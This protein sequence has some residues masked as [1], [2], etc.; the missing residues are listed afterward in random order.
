[1]T[2]KTTKVIAAC[3]FIS[4]ILGMGGAIGSGIATLNT[5]ERITTE[6]FEKSCLEQHGIAVRDVNDKLACVR[7]MSSPAY[8]PSAG[9]CEATSNTLRVV[10]FDSGP[11]K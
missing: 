6:N 7:S 1:M 3:C 9:C 11:G 8:Y 2:S 10:C 5:T 4:C